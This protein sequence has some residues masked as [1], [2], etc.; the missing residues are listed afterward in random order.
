MFLQMQQIQEIIFRGEI[1]NTKN[2]ILSV[3]DLVIKFTLRGK[4]LNVE[5]ARL[6]RILYAISEI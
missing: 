1:V 3:K 5:K 6:D 2:I 4:I